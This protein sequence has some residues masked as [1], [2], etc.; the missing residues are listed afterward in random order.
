MQRCIIDACSLLHAFHVRL[1]NFVLADLVQEHFDVRIHSEV[2]EEIARV[3]P[4]AYADW[5]RK[6]LVSKEFS[7]IRRDHATWISPKLFIGDCLAEAKLVTAANLGRLDSGEAACVALAKNLADQYVSYVV[8]ITDD[9]DAGESAKVFFKQ[10]ECG[11]VI[12]SADLI[13]F[14]GIRYK[15][16]KTEIHQSLRNLIAF[17][18]ATYEALLEQIR[19]LLPGGEHHLLH[20]LIKRNEFSRAISAIPKLPLGGATR[21]QLTTL[22]ENIERFSTEKSVLGHTLTRLHTLDKTAL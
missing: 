10:Y 20:G 13:V 3:L 15:L 12:K 19:N 17:Y 22:V 9:F 8:F 1:G 18:T 2:R 21:K 14:F 7:R 5:K 6:G 16:A 4:R 11:L